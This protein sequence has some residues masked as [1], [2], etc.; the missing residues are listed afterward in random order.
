MENTCRP[1]SST[2]WYTAGQGDAPDANDCLPP[3]SC[4]DKQAS[5]TFEKL[6][7]LKP[8][9]LKAPGTM[10]TASSIGGSTRAGCS[11]S[12]GSSQKALALEDD[13]DPLQVCEPLLIQD[14]GSPLLPGRRL[15]RSHSVEVLLGRNSAVGYTQGRMTAADSSQTE[16]W[17]IDDHGSFPFGESAPLSPVG[18]LRTAAPFRRRAM[19][20]PA[21]RNV[22]H[23]LQVPGRSGADTPEFEEEQEPDMG[24]RPHQMFG[25]SSVAALCAVRLKEVACCAWT[26]SEQS[27]PHRAAERHVD[28]QRPS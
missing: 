17:E 28:P 5:F 22:Q 8:Q 27:P 1:H 13:A 26:S 20:Q 2:E 18:A 4:I 9:R 7:T 15:Q 11:S 21:A 19:S 14:D 3:G 23:F 25:F 24:A 10:A 16:Y 6:A 12:C